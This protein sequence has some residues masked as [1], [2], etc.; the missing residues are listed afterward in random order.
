MSS[1]GGPHP[2]NW[3]DRTGEAADADA[4]VQ[5][6]E[7]TPKEA[8]VRTAE[9]YTNG[10]L[11]DAQ[12]VERLDALI[13]IV[14]SSGDR[15]FAYLMELER[16]PVL[17][18]VDPQ[19]LV[20][21]LPRLWHQHL[22]G[23]VDYSAAPNAESYLDA[24]STESLYEEYFRTAWREAPEA[25]FRDLRI[26][27]RTARVVLQ[28]AMEASQ[29]FWDATPADAAA[30]NA[31]FHFL[32]GDHQGAIKLAMDA[33]AQVSGAPVLV[34]GKGSYNDALQA[35]LEALVGHTHWFTA[36]LLMDVV[37]SYCLEHSYLAELV[38]AINVYEQSELPIRYSWLPVART[39][40]VMAP[41]LPE[42][43][44][45]SR[46]LGVLGSTVGQE[47]EG[48]IAALHV[49]RYLTLSGYPEVG[50]N[51][52]ESLL[53]F[54]KLD[55]DL[56]PRAKSGFLE[57]MELLALILLE[58]ADRG[59]GDVRMSRFRLPYVARLLARLDG[60]RYRHRDRYSVECLGEMFR[61]LARVQRQAVAHRNMVPVDVMHPWWCEHD[62]QP[63]AQL[64]QDAIL[65][66]PLFELAPLELSL[67][68][69]LVAD[70]VDLPE[71]VAQ[72]RERDAMDAETVP[73]EM[74]PA[75]YVTYTALEMHDYREIALD[76]LERE[77]PP[78]SV[79]ADLAHRGRVVD[80]SGVDEDSFEH[81]NP[82]VEA[83]LTARSE[84]A[85]TDGTD[86][87]IAELAELWYD[88]GEETKRLIEMDL[89]F[90]CS[91]PT[92]L[93]VILAVRGMRITGS[94]YSILVPHRTLRLVERIMGD[95]ALDRR[96]AEIAAQYGAGLM[97]ALPDGD[98]DPVLAL[99]LARYAGMQG[100]SIDAVAICQRV[101][102]L[103]PDGDLG[104][105][106]NE[107]RVALRLEIA[108]ALRQLGAN[109]SAG[110]IAA[111]ATHLAELLGREDLELDGE[112]EQLSNRHEAMSGLTTLGD[113]AHLAERFPLRNYPRQRFAIRAL[114]AEAAATMPEEIPGGLTAFI[115]EGEPAE[116]EPVRFEEAW[117][118]AIAE[119][120]RAAAAYDAD[121]CE[122]SNVPLRIAGEFRSVTQS[123]VSAG[124]LP[125]AVE[126][127]GWLAT[128]TAEHEGAKDPDNEWFAVHLDA[129]LGQAN[130]LRAQGKNSQA[131][132]V[133]E[134]VS[135]QAMRTRQADTF[136]SVMVELWTASKEATE[137]D[138]ASEYRRLAKE[139]AQEAVR[140][141]LVEDDGEGG[142]RR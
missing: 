105:Y 123:L 27:L 141:G 116:A 108:H 25:A 55:D 78:G 127:S 63:L 13:D 43:V 99:D 86:A 68:K 83:Y 101:C 126:L 33:I 37:C 124:R 41:F 6:E 139:I 60:S 46:V 53:P 109:G 125:Q 85:R 115:G 104:H 72:W 20:T 119:L 36:G 59:L 50:L 2:Y 81:P 110:E 57:S 7:L 112:V 135:Q 48:A 38:V 69:G 128:W 3:G 34:L 9:A 23:A 54:L 113:V 91:W 11:T 103:L 51:L 30:L 118:S 1:G 97:L 42:D 39:L 89:L 137:P 94:I 71:V 121:R 84:V 62:Q 35:Q 14:R 79:G 120:R 26:P 58:A 73:T 130:V 70:D 111:R 5:I 132:V 29:E 93:S 40:V 49:A 106:G 102:N 21:D 76:R 114:A 90:I 47:G 65:G 64:S 117:P 8:W 61:D 17:A 66:S 82:D 100:R 74:L 45:M 142:A 10:Y 131:A 4:E 16:L 28:Q 67:P 75:A 136:R 32:L 80:S 95:P 24:D 12:Y 56:P 31:R 129:L 87:S 77:C 88:V 92:E 15:G 133:Y 134:S 98:V 44:N 122:E 107:L 19:I 18:A 96:L 52:A 138:A 22:E 140:T